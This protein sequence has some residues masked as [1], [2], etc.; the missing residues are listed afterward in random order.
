MYGSPASLYWS[1]ASSSA[2]L[3]YIN[4][5]TKFA[6]GFSESSDAVIGF[7]LPSASPH[8]RSSNGSQAFGSGYEGRS[9]QGA[10]TFVIY[11]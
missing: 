7:G 6:S 9:E 1:A 3:L 2:A 10:M 8:M 5:G 4:R 11:S